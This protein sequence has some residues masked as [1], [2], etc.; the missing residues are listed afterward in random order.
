VFSLLPALSSLPVANSQ[1]QMDTNSFFFFTSVNF[2][3][4][5]SHYRLEVGNY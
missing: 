2:L 5:R 1:Q 4:L 3:N